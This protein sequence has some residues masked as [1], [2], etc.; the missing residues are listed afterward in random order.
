MLE[1]IKSNYFLRNAVDCECSLATYFENSPY[2]YLVLVDGIPLFW[3][4]DY[5]PV[6]FGSIED[7]QVEINSYKDDKYTYSI[8]TEKEYLLN[9]CMDAIEETLIKHIK[10]KGEYDGNC[11]IKWLDNSFYGVINLDGGYT[12]ILGAFVG[13]DNLL[14]FLVSDKNDDNQDFVDMHHFD[15]EVIFNIIKT[16]LA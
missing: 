2:N 11:H 5:T 16:I 1:S 7:A 6:I 12:D 10:E 14:S 4:G 3:A 13:T 8:I 15:K 9:Y